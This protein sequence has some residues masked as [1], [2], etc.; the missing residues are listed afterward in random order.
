MPV[1]FA[2][3]ALIGSDLNLKENVYIITTTDFS[4]TPGLIKSVTEEKPKTSVKEE[5]YDVLLMP[6]FVNG[7]THIGDSAAKDLGYGAEIED[8]VGSQGMKFK[9]FEKID[10]KDLVEAM[11]DA[12]SEML[13]SG[14]TAFADFRE[15]G[16]YG[17]EVLKEA[18][19]DLPIKTIA[20]GRPSKG[21]I[22]SAKVL[23]AGDGFGLPSVDQYTEEELQIF[24]EMCL[25]KGKL[26]ATHVLETKKNCSNLKATSGDELEKV[27]RYL[28]RPSFLVHLTHANPKQLRRVAELGIGV[29]CCPRGNAYFGLG[30]PPIAEMLNSGI[31]PSIGTD[32]QIS[33]SANMFSEME[34]LI[35]GSRLFRKKVLD[36]KE[37]LKMATVYG[38]T[39]LR[40]DVGVIREGALADFILIDLKAPNIKHSSDI[41]RGLTL[42]A[43]PKNVKQ[44][45][46]SGSEVKDF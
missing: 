39:V 24:S 33:C 46:I 31:R 32:N 30:F 14:I 13:L 6:G 18:V 36:P 38:G 4:N 12:V 40:R 5:F 34:F 16:F 1:F 42:R 45:F 7:H 35:R 21:F 25:K 37:V 26:L 22:D 29:V 10:R 41:Y 9:V 44:V 2:E 19:S 17:L 20:L 28:K 11:R 3:K 15:S 43:N 27:L 8:V 23:D